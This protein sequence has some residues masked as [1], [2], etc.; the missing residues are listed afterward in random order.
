MASLEARL[1]SEL[2]QEPPVEADWI[3]EDL[4]PLGGHVIA[5]PPKCGKSWLCLPIG[6][7]VSSGAVLELCRQKVRCSTCV[8]KTPMSA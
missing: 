5:G 3:I 2:I 4:L 1:A 6:L 7:T 8:W